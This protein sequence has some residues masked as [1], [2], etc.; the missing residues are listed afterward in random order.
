MKEKATVGAVAGGLNPE[1]SL[2]NEAERF[3][4]L[5]GKDPAK[6]WFRCIRPVQGPIRHG[7][8]TDL[9]GFDE[10]TLEA[11]N[12]AGASIYFITGDADQATGKNNDGKPTGAVE[13]HDVHACRA[14][15][16]EWDSNPVE[17]QSQAWRELG[18]PEP[19]AMVKTGGKSVHCYWALTEPLPPDEWRV[20]TQR[21]IKH[22]DSDKYCSNPSRL[23][24]L[25]GFDYIDKKTGKPNGQRAELI[26]DTGTRYTLQQILDC[27]P[28]P[29]PQLLN[30][31]QSGP[32]ASSA[33]KAA[34]DLPPRPESSVI[35]ALRQV[36]EFKHDQ[37]R[38][39]EL[40]GLAL[41]LSVELGTERAHELMAQHS[42]TVT[43]LPDLFKKAPER[44][45][46]GS[47]WPFLNEHYGIDI[48]R[49]DL[50]R[51]LGPSGPKAAKF[52]PSTNSAT[53]RGKRKLGFSRRMACFEKCVRVQAARERNSLRRR[54]RL[55]NVVSDLDLKSSIN[56]QDIAQRVLEV[57]DQDQG[58]AYRGLTAADRLTMKWPE[59]DW[60]IPGLL[61][62]N[63]LSI[64]GGRPKVGKTAM[65]MAIAAA[66]L[67][68]IRLV[69]FDPP[70]TS[71]P[72]IVIS[73]DQGDADTK[74]ALTQLGIFDHPALIWSRRFRL[75]ES[76]L[77]RLLLDIRN[78]PGALVVLDSLRSVS[79]ALPHGENDPEIGAVIYDL[80]A[81][82]MDAGG[83]LLLVHHCNKTPGLTGVEALSGHNAIAGAA[84]TV[85]TLHYVE[86]EKGQP[87]KEALQ[88][89]MVREGRTGKPLDCVISRTA[90]TAS[91]HLVGTWA[92]WQEQIEQSTQEAKQE[93]KQTCSKRDVLEVLQE[94]P[95]QMLTCREVVETMGLDWGVGRGTGKDPS[96]VRRAL[97]ALADENQIKR[98]RA[99]TEYTFGDK[100]IASCSTSVKNVN[101]VSNTAAQSIPALTPDVS[102]VSAHDTPPPPADTVDIR[103][104]RSDQLQ[105]K[106][107][108]AV[109]TADTM[110]APA[111]EVGQPVELLEPATGEWAAGWRVEAVESTTR[112]F[113]VAVSC[114]ETRERRVVNPNN[115]RTSP[116]LIHPEVVVDLLD[117]PS[118]E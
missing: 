97:N 16:V 55:L 30:V 114:I 8:G 42:P 39:D 46:Q 66:V 75:T 115:L 86:N 90:G 81:A 47:L 104:Q 21:L 112:G 101:T 40:L 105:L 107:A 100:V 51:E 71:R 83:S 63:D 6:T 23:M 22:C 7:N 19:S 5:L 76:D 82:V 25:P 14:L 12:K 38:R 3:L 24:R 113:K 49:H 27:L 43:D 72:V 58:N 93:A 87:D 2:P 60:L 32:F 45:S 108:D 54:A 33:R 48:R 65:A 28:E 84:N 62:A 77:D 92:S 73:D 26:H 36:P 94:H 78:N 11:D 64:I 67:K 96:R 9:Q 80:K 15:F 110:G 91:F 13:D 41:R 29:E 31:K 117:P 68:Q 52:T 95:G 34:A 89:R 44:I 35:D 74:E 61:P 4:Q 59:V 57:K 50:K 106:G 99:G 118:G 18:L 69:S 98:V 1:T 116:P 88:R 20:V 17:W 109:D 79:R 53:R 103:C 56:R 10:A 102:G 85:I 111:L 37:G 70:A